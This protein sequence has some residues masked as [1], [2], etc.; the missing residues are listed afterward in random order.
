MLADLTLLASMFLGLVVQGST[1]CPTPAEVATQLKPLLP[2]EFG[3]PE[4]ILLLTTGSGQIDLALTSEGGDIVARRQL[5]H[6]GSCVAQAKR[7]AVVAAAW[8]AELDDEALPPP[9]KAEP[10]A[11]QVEAATPPPS[12]APTSSGDLHFEMGVRASATPGPSF[13]ME[14]GVGKRWGRWGILGN[15]EGPLIAALLGPTFFLL[16]GYPTLLVRAQGVLALG[17]TSGAEVGIT[18]V[19]TLGAIPGVELG[20]RVTMGASGARGFIDLAYAHY[21]SGDSPPPNQGIIS[22]G[23]ALGGP[24]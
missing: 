21:F 2:E 13:L 22:V 16:E 14:L 1:D 8:Q 18:Q 19:S 11:L 10:P 9:P 15:V 3:H 17:T 7:V 12:T 20:V 23:L 6:Q 5:P 24:G 4:R